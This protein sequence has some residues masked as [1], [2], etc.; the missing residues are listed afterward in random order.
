MNPA[1]MYAV[2]ASFLFALMN[3]AAK[4]LSSH[5]TVP[6]IVFYRGVIGIALTLSIMRWK[7][8]PFEV[9]NWPLLVSRGLFGGASLLLA[10]MA[11]SSI[12]LT[13]AS[14]L[15][16]LS[17]LFTVCLGT[18][19]LKE[20]MPRGFSP[21]LITA[22]AGALL[23]ASPWQ[24]S[25]HA[26]YAGIGVVGAFLASSA[27]LAI[28]RLSVDHN[29]YTIML[30][31]LAAATV[32][33]IPF[34]NWSEQNIPNFKTLV[35]VL[36]LGSVSFLGQY[37]L[38][39]AYRLERAGVVAMTRYVGVLFHLILG[40]L[41]WRELPSLAGVVGGLMILIASFRLSRLLQRKT[42]I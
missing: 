35:A 8:I 26:Y 18:L 25:I 11:I 17:P 3:A 23:V 37:C 1:L 22:C 7:K 39:Q 32:L 34:V 42:E 20:A 19:V 12:A 2:C 30:G 27:S 28:R 40:Y 33:P 36:L 16:H 31:F 6:E 9:K 24:A 38:T 10:F 15:A 21:L 13:E 41:V 4:Y 29:N 5:M 14:F